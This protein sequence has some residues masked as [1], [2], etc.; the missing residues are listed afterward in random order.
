VGGS[1]GPIG[2]H[3]VLQP[4]AHRKTI[5][6][7]PHMHN[8]HEIATALLEA[9]GALEVHNSGALS[10][11][12]S[13]LLQRSERRQALGEAAYQV[14]RDDQGAIARTVQ[15]IKQVLSQHTRV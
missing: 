13:A 1:F 4:A 10:E 15:L 11:R 5:L 14:L 3:N 9:G 2:G 6:F 12:V 8:F 7:G